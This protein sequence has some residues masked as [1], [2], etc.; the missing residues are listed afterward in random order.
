VGLGLRPGGGAAGVA[1]RSLEGGGW[2]GLGGSGPAPARASV[3]GA[4]RSDGGRDDRLPASAA[5]GDFA[6]A[7]G[8][9]AAGLAG[10][11]STAGAFVGAA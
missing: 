11:P 1:G 7:G 8:L 5:G 3:A 10:E 6:G 9:E 2:A 4:G